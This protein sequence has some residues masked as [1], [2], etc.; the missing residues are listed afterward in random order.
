MTQTAA[1]APSAS[2]VWRGRVLI[3]CQMISRLR[4]RY[5][6]TTAAT[7]TP[8]KK[9]PIWNHEGRLKKKRRTAATPPGSGGGPTATCCNGAMAPKLA[10]ARLARALGRHPQS[11]RRRGGDTVR[12]HRQRSEERR[13]G[14]GGRARAV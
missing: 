1:A 4:H 11:R 6:A 2:C 14:K 12:R 5:T 7:M 8:K 10:L 9:P 13:V 3:H